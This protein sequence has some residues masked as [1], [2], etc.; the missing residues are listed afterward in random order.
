MTYLHE[1][2]KHA[3]PSPSR[4]SQSFPGIKVVGSSAV[5]AHS[6]QDA[7]ST[8]DFA[9]GHWPSGTIELCLR[10]GD[11]VPVVDAANISPNVDWVLDDCFVV[12]PANVSCRSAVGVGR[13]HASPASMHSTVLDAIS[14]SRFAT[15]RPLIPQPTT[16]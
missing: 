5:P 10:Y 11:E 3:T 12:V 14:D 6:I 4:V 8:K 16:M 13:T 15:T 2:G 9:L 1:I 7:A